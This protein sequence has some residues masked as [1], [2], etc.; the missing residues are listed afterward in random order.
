M[1]KHAS[2]DVR[3]AQLFEAAMAVCAEKGYHA[4]TIDDIAARAGLSKGA[5]YHHF[6]SKQDLFV[7]MLEGS[8]DEFAAMIDHA[9][10]T[11]SARDAIQG[12]VRT[13]LR[14]FGPEVRQGLA[15][16]YMLGLREPAFAARFRR[17]YDGMIAA[18]ARLLRRGIERGE[19]RA[20]LDPARASQLLFI[21]TDGLM[22]MYLVLGRNAEADAYVME[23]VDVLLDGFAAPR[24][25]TTK[26]G[27][28]ARL[29][30][31][32]GRRGARARSRARR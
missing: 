18:G 9:E 26:E 13:A 21:G 20:E 2:P 27:T 4:T 10:P 24:A 31:D 28:D 12:V 29:D 5:V 30:S 32:R 22:F 25:V 11:G 19:F 3:R 15:D 1:V 16:F 14:A 6:R 23:L 17:H 7:E 8:V